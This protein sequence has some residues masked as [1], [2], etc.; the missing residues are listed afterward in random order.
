MGKVKYCE[1]YG[2]KRPDKKNHISR[3]YSVETEDGRTF[4][5]YIGEVEQVTSGRIL[6]DYDN[7]HKVA[8]A[9]N[10]V[11]EA[12]AQR[13]EDNRAE[14]QRRKIRQTRYSPGKK[15]VYSTRTEKPTRVGVLA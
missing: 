9:F 10:D 8:L 5:V 3:Q 12:R 11:E 13:A 6:I 1:G 2:G 15:I 14:Q 4:A 7:M